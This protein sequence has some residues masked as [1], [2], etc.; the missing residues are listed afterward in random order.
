MAQMSSQESRNGTTNFGLHFLSSFLED[1]MDRAIVLAAAVACT[2]ISSLGRNS[3]METHLGSKQAL[4]PTT[5]R[6][7]HSA[8]LQLQ[9]SSGVCFSALQFQTTSY[10][11]EVSQ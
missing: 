3:G 2:A 11:R 8:Q 7:M 1:S 10:M 6:M 9:Q 4:C 5:Q